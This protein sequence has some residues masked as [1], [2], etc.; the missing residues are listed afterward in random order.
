MD[1]WLNWPIVMPARPRP[2]KAEKAKGR[3]TQ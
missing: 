2:E 1:N 3:S